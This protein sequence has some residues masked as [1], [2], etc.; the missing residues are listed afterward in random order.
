[1]N[2]TRTDHESVIEDRDSISPDF[3]FFVNKPEPPTIT[4]EEIV[5]DIQQWLARDENECSQTPQT[6]EHIFESPGLLETY[7]NPLETSILQFPPHLIVSLLKYALFTKDA[8]INNLSESDQKRLK[9]DAA[10]EEKVLEEYPMLATHLIDSNLFLR[11]ML[12]VLPESLDFLFGCFASIDNLSSD[13]DGTIKQKPL[14]QQEEQQEDPYTKMVHALERFVVLKKPLNKPTTTS[15]FQKYI[16]FHLDFPAYSRLLKV[17]TSTD[18]Y[19]T[20]QI[21]N[22]LTANNNQILR[23]MYHVFQ[24]DQQ[25]LM[26]V[27]ALITSVFVVEPQ[28]EIVNQLVASLDDFTIDQLENTLFMMSLL[29]NV[30]S[31]KLVHRLLNAINERHDQLSYSSHQ[32]VLTLLKHTLPLHSTCLNDT[33]IYMK[34]L[35]AS[36]SSLLRMLAMDIYFFILTELSHT[37]ALPP[38]YVNLLETFVSIFFDR[39]RFNIFHDR[40]VSLILYFFD[41]LLHGDST[42]FA[43]FVLAFFESSFFKKASLLLQSSNSLSPSLSPS[44]VAH[45]G[46]LLSAFFSYFERFIENDALEIPA[47]VNLPVLSESS[48]LSFHNNLVHRSLLRS[49]ELG[50]D[51]EVPSFHLTPPLNEVVEEDDDNE[52]ILDS[53][54]DSDSSGYDDH[55]ILTSELHEINY[56]VEM[57]SDDGEGDDDDDDDVKLITILDSK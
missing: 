1:M 35:L 56:D 55:L 37:K 52:E 24:K 54:D 11:C 14:W 23:C 34:H 39:P 20:N 29:Q 22:Y 49:F 43:P 47:S 12:G 48:L 7:L 32:H 5:K 6:I 15:V 21:V 25:L 53:D 38:P 27:A 57:L 30:V 40:F 17:L 36:S 33:C 4:T 8:L 51:S 26:C 44:N 42:I 45:V 10:F 18:D 28:N 41:Q 19:L 16:L 13:M 46:D 3:E 31:V 2:V 9:N 50:S